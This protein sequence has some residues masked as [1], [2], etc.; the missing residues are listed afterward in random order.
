MRDRGALRL[1]AGLGGVTII[2]SL[3]MPWAE[4]AGT[5]RTGWE[6]WTTADV[7]LLLTA[8]CAIAAAVTGGRFGLFRPDLSLI[9]AAD[10]LG[11]VSALL[12]VW[13]LGFDFPPGAEREPGAFVA[14]LGAVAVF[15]G[16]G[17]YSTFRGAPLF[18]P[19]RS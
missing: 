13:L 9:G 11:V 2:G 16:A 10:L 7:F 4:V 8:V 12:L 6:L 5:S 15:S 19:L 3:F 17:D 14:L 1:L 18:P